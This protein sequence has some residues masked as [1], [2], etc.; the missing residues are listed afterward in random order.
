MKYII[1]WRKDIKV[2]RFAAST[3]GGQK[4]NKTAC[5]VRLTH[6]PTQ[7]VAQSIGRSYTANMERATNILVERIVEH[8]EAERAKPRKESIA[9]GTHRRTYYD[10]DN[11][12][13]VDHKTGATGQFQNVINGE[14]DN[15]IQEN[16]AC[17]LK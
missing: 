8:L 17:H 15:F 14:I 16:L 6:K 1:N 13:V 10:I 9:R 11:N 2:E 5:N 3:M 7:I 4:A 12:N